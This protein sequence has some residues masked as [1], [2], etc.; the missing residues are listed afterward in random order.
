LGQKVKNDVLAALTDWKAGKPVRALELGHTQ[1][2][3][4]RPGQSPVIG[5]EF[6][7]QD[8]ERAYAY[9]FAIIDQ[10]ANA[11]DATMVATATGVAEFFA[12]YERFSWMCGE[13]SKHFSG[14]T[15]EERDGAESL[16]WKALRFGWARAIAGHS[17]E[18][19]IEVS[20]PAS[21]V[22]PPASG[23]QETST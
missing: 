12:I 20:L 18:S 7:P 6:F 14:L 2:M 3:V 13:I 10:A 11:T 21:S 5:E 19:Y 16:A 17:P 15:P 9:C 23:Q 22:Q 8:Q 1:R 4:E